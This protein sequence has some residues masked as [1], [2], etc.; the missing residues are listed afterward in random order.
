MNTF[1]LRKVNH[2]DLWE[3]QFLI[4][5]V[6]FLIKIIKYIIPDVYY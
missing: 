1:K 3:S 2:Y 4:S 6:P 5:T